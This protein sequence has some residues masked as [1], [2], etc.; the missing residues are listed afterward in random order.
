MAVGHVYQLAHEL[1]SPKPVENVI[2]ADF[3]QDGRLDLVLLTVN[4]GTDQGWW[5][6]GDDDLVAMLHIQ[7]KDGVPSKPRPSI[8]LSVDK[9]ST[10]KIH[11]RQQERK[12]FTSRA[13]HGTSLSS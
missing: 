1:S 7:E 5:A 12:A 4:D 11:F 2:P 10:V 13:S 9:L 6:H 3:N 8:P